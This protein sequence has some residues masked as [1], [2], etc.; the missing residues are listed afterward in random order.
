MWR[1]HEQALICY[2]AAIC[3]RWTT[4]G[5]GDTVKGK[6]LAYSLRGAR[7]QDE[8]ASEGRLPPWLGDAQLH[9]SHQS[10][11]LRKN[12]GWYRQYFPDIPDDLPYFWPV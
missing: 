7:T 6:L 8:L 9:R 3:D 11:L 5:Y 12:P 2:G 4:L 10:A 1:G